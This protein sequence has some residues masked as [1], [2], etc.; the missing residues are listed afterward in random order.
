MCSP[1]VSVSISS[2]SGALPRTPG[3]VM[4]D[5]ENAHEALLIEDDPATLELL[6]KYVR[7]LGHRVRV[8]TTLLE[9]DAAI[10]AGGFCYVLLDKQIPQRAGELPVVAMGDAAQKHIRR[11][12]SRRHADDAHVLPILVITAFSQKVD[13]VAH[14]F[15]IGASGFLSKESDAEEV[16]REILAMLVRARRED[17]AAC[18][19]LALPPETKPAPAVLMEAGPVVTLTLDGIRI[20]RRSSFL[21]N[22]KR[23]NLQDAR[24]V[25][26]LRL[27]VERDRGSDR[28]LTAGELGILRTPETPS[29][30]QDAFEG[31]VPEGFLVLERGGQ[32][33]RRLHPLVAIAPIDW[34]ALA[35]HPFAAISR[36][37]IAEQKRT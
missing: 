25:V 15:L 3:A 13:F 19:A 30:I 6:S 36:I 29:R 1:C 31:A 7:S 24:F 32:G 22:G 28:Y 17:H 14:N 8:A 33:A 10:A 20:G 26:L 9:A 18:A 37:A 21:V 5:S 35:R 34:A 11:R 12:D 23:R 16:T 4:C 27:V 2:R